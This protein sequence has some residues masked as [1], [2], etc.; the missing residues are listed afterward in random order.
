LRK[1]TGLTQ[2]E[3]AEK[4]NITRTAVTK[5][6]TGKTLP[7]YQ[8]LINIAKIF[9]VSTDY[10]LGLKEQDYPATKTQAELIYIIKKL[11]N[12]QTEN[13]K[14][15]IAGILKKEEGN[16]NKRSYSLE[17]ELD[18]IEFTPE[19]LSLKTA[20]KADKKHA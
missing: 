16:K 3:L 8:T 17:Q 10:L 18:E 11:D 1:N 12:M 14:G 9:C 15:Y 13:V 19:E 5:W 4:L 6:E 2:A 7:D 20:P